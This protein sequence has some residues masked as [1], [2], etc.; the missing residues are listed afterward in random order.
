MTLS[1]GTEQNRISF[2]YL[3]ILRLFHTFTRIRQSI[4]DIQKQLSLYSI[5]KLNTFCENIY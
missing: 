3:I 4:V 5:A 1:P 2:F